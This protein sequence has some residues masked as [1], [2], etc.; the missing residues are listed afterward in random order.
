MQKAYQNFVNDFLYPNPQN[1]LVFLENHDTG[2]FNEI[3]DQDIKAYQ[4]GMALIATTR[5]IPQLYYGSEIGMRGDKSKGDGDIRRDFPG[6]WEGDE[7]NAFQDSERTKLQENFHSFTKKLLNF[8]KNSKAIHHGKLTHYLPENNVYVYFRM[9][10]DEK[11]MVILNNN[12]EEQNLS[13]SRF[14]ENLNGIS[15]GKE[16]LSGK[17]LQLTEKL[18][19]SGKTPMVIQL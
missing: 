18:T 6:G 13:L 8:R 19:I 16:I 3:Y 4:L 7:Q 15:I 5:G 12:E 14:Q 10:E 1:L 9:F 2:R 11:V 17:Q